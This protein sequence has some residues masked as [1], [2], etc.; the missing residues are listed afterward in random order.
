MN[1]SVLIFLRPDKLRV[2]GRSETFVKSR[3]RFK[4]ERITVKP[5]KNII[6]NSKNEKN[7]FI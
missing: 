1:V 6:E 2:V 4:N 3:S 7:S 5:L